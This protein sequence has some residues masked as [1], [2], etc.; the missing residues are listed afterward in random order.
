MSVTLGDIVLEDDM[1]LRG[2]QTDRVAVDV[3]RSDAGV[4][5]ILIADVEGGQSLELYG[6]YTFDQEEQILALSA[7]KGQVILDHPRFNGLVI[8]TGTSLEDLDEFANP[9]GD[10]IRVGVVNLLRYS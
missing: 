8:I 10:D 1:I 5:Q 3:Q 4:A 9:D 7:G 2:L 6:W